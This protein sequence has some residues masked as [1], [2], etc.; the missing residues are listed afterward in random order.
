MAK[1]PEEEN[2]HPPRQENE[3]QGIIDCQIDISIK[4][5]SKADRKVLSLKAT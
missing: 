4:E 2:N 5:D 1:M 3:I